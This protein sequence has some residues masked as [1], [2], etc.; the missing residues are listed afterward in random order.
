MTVLSSKINSLAW[1][2]TSEKILVGLQSGKVIE[3]NKPEKEK[4]DTS[5]SFEVALGQRA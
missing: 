4:I 1:H 5:H 3:I 2:V